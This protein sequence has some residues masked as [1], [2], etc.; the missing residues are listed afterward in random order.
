MVAQT[1]SV[2]IDTNHFREDLPQ[3]WNIAEER[4][5]TPSNSTQLI[6]QTANRCTERIYRQGYNY[7]R[8]GVVVMDNSPDNNVQTYFIDYNPE[9]HEKMKKPDE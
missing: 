2:F 6:V 5:L 3:Y 4:M 7:K 1:V 9:R 8:A